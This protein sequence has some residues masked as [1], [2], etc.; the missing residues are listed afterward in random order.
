MKLEDA[1]DL[2]V[3]FGETKE[4]KNEKYKKI[5]NFLK[6]NEEI[7]IDNESFERVYFDEFQP[8]DYFRVGV[9]LIT[10]IRL[11]NKKNDKEIEIIESQIIGPYKKYEY[12]SNFDFLNKEIKSQNKILKL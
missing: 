12:E 1:I 5:F 11:K 7:E 3:L 4:E 9:F 8:E 2:S 10:T 6:E